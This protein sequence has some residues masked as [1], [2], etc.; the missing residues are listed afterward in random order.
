M[1]VSQGKSQYPM[2]ASFIMAVITSLTDPPTNKQASKR[3]SG[4][5]SLCHLEQ[6]TL[7]AAGECGSELSCP[8][9]TMSVPNLRGCLLAD[10]PRCL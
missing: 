10:Q 6:A 4:W 1:R 5:V 3:A 8:L 9:S 7:A 2:A